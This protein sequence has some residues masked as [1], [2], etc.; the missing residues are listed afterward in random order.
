MSDS[1]QTWT[2]R[3]LLAWM[4]QSFTERGIDAP[5]RMAEELLAHSLGCDRLRLYM[6]ADRPASPIELQALRGLVRRALDHEPIQY[7]VG[8]ESFYGLRFKTDRRA[9]IPRPCTRTLVDAVLDH[10]K[11]H[12]ATAGGRERDAGAG[13][14]IGELCTG[15]GC[16]AVAL[17]KNLPGARIVATDL[18]EDAL[19]L[20]AENAE[21]HEVTDRI[22]FERGNLFGAFDAHAVARQEGSLAALAANPPYVPDDEWGDMAPNVTDHEPTLAIRGGSDGM[23]LVR[24]I[25]EQGPARLATGGVLAIEVANSRTPEVLALAQAHPLLTDARIDK[26]EDGLDRVLVALRK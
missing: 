26:D 18:S 25:I 13:L 8:E 10:F 11:G 5:K 12:P 22:D 20:A 4:A 16:V 17:A 19:A 1:P 14:L 9:L 3:T 21:R 23:D 7:L 6:D 15:T 2:T 24:P